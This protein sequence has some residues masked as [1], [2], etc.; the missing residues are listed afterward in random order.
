MLKKGALKMHFLKLLNSFSE[1]FYFKKQKLY[2]IFILIFYSSVAHSF[3]SNSQYALLID[4]DTDQILY[5]KNYKA[6][7][8]P[9]SMSKLMTLYILFDYLDNNLSLIHI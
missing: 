1:T 4:Y 7:I 6:K 2:F 5:E 9:A 8:Y 3:N